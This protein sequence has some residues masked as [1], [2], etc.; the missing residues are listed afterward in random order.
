MLPRSA[1]A[2]LLWLGVGLFVALELGL[3]IL[4]GTDSRWNVRLGADKQPDP[5]VQFRLKPNQDL[6][7]GVLTNEYG[8]LAPRGL[9]RALPPDRL[10]VLYLGDSNTVIPRDANYPQQVEPRVEAALGIEV[11]TVNAAVPGYSSENARLLFEHELSDFDAD[12]LFVYLGW[13]DLGQYGPEGL[14]Y[15]RRD[16]GYELSALQ[17]ALTNVYSL[18]F[19]YAARQLWLHRRPTTDQP[20]APE[21]AALYAGYRPAHFDANLRAILERARERYPNVVLLSLAT[22]TSEAPSDRELRIA[23]FPTG[24]DKNVRKLHQLVGTYNAVVHEVANDLGVQVIDLYAL[25]DNP[26]ARQHFTD[27]CHMDAQGAAR[28]AEAVAERI[29]AAERARASLPRAGATAG[30]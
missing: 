8:Y 20:L 27:S 19:L 3:R 30:R 18:R 23:H 11:E 24:M 9:E 10:R 28:I 1:T 25:F 17:R 22:I 21:D 5:V 16:Q 26:A 4:T 14:P 12:W 29:I 15:K 13:N 7:D 2:R 6:G